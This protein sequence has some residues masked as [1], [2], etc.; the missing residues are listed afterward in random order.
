MRC[1]LDSCRSPLS[2]GEGVLSDFCCLYVAPNAH[3][4]PT[5]RNWFAR[6]RR[7]AAHL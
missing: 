1:Y 2:V 5:L 3:K 6:R 4:K 7:R